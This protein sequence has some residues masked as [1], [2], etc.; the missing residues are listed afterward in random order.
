MGDSD[1]SRAASDERLTRGEGDDEGTGEAAEVDT[2]EE[3][4]FVI[5]GF[6]SF[7]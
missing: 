1:V 6:F 3:A 2:V 4:R 5:T 7:P